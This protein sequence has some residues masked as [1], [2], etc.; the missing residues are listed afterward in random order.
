MI[1]TV[2]KS[3]GTYSDGDLILFEKEI[4]ER[5]VKK[6]EVLL[7]VG[8]VNTSVFFNV[9]GAFCQYHFRDETELNVIDLHMENEWFFNQASFVAQ[10]P[11]ENIIKAYS[12]SHILEITV[13]SIHQLI[14]IS[15]AFLQ[16]GKIIA[17]STSRLH[18][19]DNN[20][21]P[22]QKYQYI[23]DNRP[24]LIQAFPLKIIASWLKVSPETLSRVREKFTRGKAGS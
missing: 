1:S 4:R 22:A 20:L 9:A 2:L 15:P 13:E 19:F 7:G 16:L 24:G 3:N 17:H 11:S 6:D 12:D 14:A 18:F 23:L 10:K 8:E 21:T 5:H